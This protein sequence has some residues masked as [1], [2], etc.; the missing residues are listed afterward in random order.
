MLHLVEH[1]HHIAWVTGIALGHPIGKDKAGGGLRQHAGFATKLG[2]TI[3]FAFDDGCNRRVI[4]I[5][6]FVLG[7]LFALG[8]A[9][10]LFGDVPMRRT[11][12]LQVAP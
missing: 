9:L 5:D 12:S 1:G 2:G 8:E 11:G 7:E 4:G 10:R 6:N 3:A